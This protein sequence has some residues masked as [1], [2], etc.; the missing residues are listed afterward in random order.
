MADTVVVFEFTLGEKI[1]FSLGV[2]PPGTSEIDFSVDDVTINL[3]SEYGARFTFE[4][5]PTS[6]TAIDPDDVFDLV[7]DELF[8][9]LT[10]AWTAQNLSE[11]RWTMSTSVFNPVTEQDEVGIVYLDMVRRPGGSLPVGS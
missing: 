1:R 6:G 4:W 9:F 10:S 3:D 5:R 8:F 7:D 11:G 2:S